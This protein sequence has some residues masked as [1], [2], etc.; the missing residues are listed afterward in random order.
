MKRGWK[1][2]RLA[3]GDVL[4]AQRFGFFILDE[5]TVHLDSENTR[6]LVEVLTNSSRAVK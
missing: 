3:I 6:R 4:G 2:N 5:P 1:V